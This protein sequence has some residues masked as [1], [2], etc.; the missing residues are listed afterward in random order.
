MVGVIVSL[1][2]PIVGTFLVVR[3]YSLMADTLSHVSLLGIAVSMLLQVNPYIGS[4]VF[5]VMASLLIEKTKDSSK[6][7]Q[8]SIL[9]MFLSGSL[10]ISII[11]IS[12]ANFNV[13]LVNLLFGSITTVTQ[14]DLYVIGSLAIM[15][16]GAIFVMFKKLFLISFDEEL[17]IASG[18]KTKLYNYIFIALVA[19]TVSF[20]IR[21]V[22]VLLIGAL[23]VIPVITAIQM[24]KGF[25]ATMLIAVMI[26]FLSV[27]IGLISS[28]Y[29]EFSSGGTIV[30]LTLIFFVLVSFLQK[31]RQVYANYY[32]KKSQKAGI[33][34]LG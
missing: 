11:I 16:A 29:L 19:V 23:M 21:I 4:S 6:L 8:E 17:A 15:V 28:Y 10:A 30:V 27:L 1:L 3:R 5:A 32:H 24:Q 9:A 12:S 13:N 26:S 25:K 7:Y 14:V 22:G 34:K 2:A 33:C 31:S 20:S 18:V